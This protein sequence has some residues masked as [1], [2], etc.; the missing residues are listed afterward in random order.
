[1][2]DPSFWYCR[3]LKFIT[4]T[5]KHNSFELK[6]INRSGSQ[7]FTPSKITC[8]TL[9][10]KNKEGVSNISLTASVTF[11]GKEEGIFSVVCKRV[12]KDVY[13]WFITV[14][15]IK[16]G[17]QIWNIK[18][19]NHV[20]FRKIFS[21]FIWIECIILI[22]V[23]GNRIFFIIKSYIFLYTLLAKISNRYI[24]ISKLY[25]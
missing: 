20:I 17:Y 7:N 16:H 11:S 2:A 21:W 8:F 13:E 14:N 25:N 1:M 9:A 23:E 3:F 5:A 22:L 10:S 24:E 4:S 19:G 6:L 18:E 15:S 12:W